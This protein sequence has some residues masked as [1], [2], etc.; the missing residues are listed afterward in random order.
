MNIHASALIFKK[1][2]M[3]IFPPFPFPESLIKY[4]TL[5]SATQSHFIRFYYT[6]YAISQ[7]LLS[8]VLLYQTLMPLLF[9]KRNY[10]LRN[11]SAWVIWQRIRI[12]S[13]VA[14]E[15][16]YIYMCVCVCVYRW[17]GLIILRI[18]T[19]SK[20]CVSSKYHNNWFAS[21][22]Y[23]HMMFALISEDNGLKN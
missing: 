20:Y 11:I 22:T 13:S 4:D 23:I 10:D 16:I 21:L 2:D 8:N 15:Y 6:Y 9:L 3:N 12:S 19:S 5:F 14:T 17:W 1:N 7:M 18:I